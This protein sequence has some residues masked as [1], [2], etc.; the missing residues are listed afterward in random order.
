M[1]HL[2]PLEKKWTL[3]NLLGVIPML[4]VVALWVYDRAKDAET[5]PA[6]Q[7]IQASNSQRIAVLEAQHRYTESRY[8]EIIARLERLDSKLSES[9]TP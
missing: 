3:G 9:R 2:P 7:G 6:I 8:A 1:P 4:F 5:I